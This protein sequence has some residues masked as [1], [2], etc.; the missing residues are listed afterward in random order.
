MR[1][2]I[3]GQDVLVENL[4]NSTPKWIS[5][6]II[7]KTGPLSYKVEIEGVIHRQ[8]VDQ[9]LPSTAQVVISDMNAEEDM[10]LPTSVN[11]PTAPEPA[12]E[13]ITHPC[14]NP[15]RH[16]RPFDHLTY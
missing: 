7:A 16:R 5:G 15:P 1:E 14:R 10:F 11:N 8:H 4:R 6:K 2:F 13:Q 12:P 9:M 3:L